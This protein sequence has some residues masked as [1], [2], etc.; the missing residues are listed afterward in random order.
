M[1]LEQALIQAKVPFDIV[2][3][4]NLKDL[5]KYRVLALAGQEC[6]SDGQMQLIRD[7]V[8]RGGGLVATGRTSLYTEWRQRRRDFGLQDLFRVNA[9]AW[10]GAKGDEKTPDLTP[11]RNAVAQGRVSY[12]PVIRPATP[13]PAAAPMTS[14]YWALPLNWQEVI[15]AVKWA[16]GD[17]LSYIVRAPATIAAEVVE[18]KEKQRLLV[19]LI[20]YDAARTPVVRNIEVG[21]RLPERRAAGE[22]TVL[23]PDEERTQ[24]VAATMK[25]GAAEFIVPQLKT[26][27]VAVVPLK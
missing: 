14:R 27:T 7:W 9:P 20:N 26:Y 15:S 17:R 19:H 5:A 13:K 21:L 12:I 4:E 22:I 11:V 3:D 18:Q 1:L 23:S 25:A 10:A 2:F 8:K 6:L 24:T 16:A